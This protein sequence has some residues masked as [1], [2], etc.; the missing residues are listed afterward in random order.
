[1]KTLGYHGKMSLKYVIIEFT[2]VPKRAGPYLQLHKVS[3]VIVLSIE[4]KLTRSKNKVLNL[5]KPNFLKLKHH[6]P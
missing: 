6:S 1:M 5:F 2:H 3:M 4:V